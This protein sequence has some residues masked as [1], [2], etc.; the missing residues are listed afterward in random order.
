[1][2]L[3]ITPAGEVRCIYGEELDLRALGR[4]DIRRGSHVEPTA[5]GRWTA[6]LAP[7]GGPIL[8]P[9]EQRCSALEA[10]IA[11]LAEHWLIRSDEPS[12]A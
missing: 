7:V 8:G 10:E 4:P 6:D 12:P 9:F 2:E 11:W 3:V 1:M 5:D